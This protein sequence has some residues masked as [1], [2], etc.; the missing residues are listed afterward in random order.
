[1]TPP[2]VEMFLALAA[3]GL[4]LGACLGLERGAML[5]VLW[6]DSLWQSL[7]GKKG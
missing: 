1:M 4:L 6:A 3:L 5:C 2:I 7:F